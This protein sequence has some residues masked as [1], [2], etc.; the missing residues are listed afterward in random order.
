MRLLVVSDVHTEFHRDGGA[1]FISSLNPEGVDALVVA[2]DLCLIRDIVDVATRLC[3]RFP[4]VLYVTG[5][6]EYYHSTP[7]LVEEDVSAVA[8]AHSNFHWLNESVVTIHGQRFVGT[9]LWFPLNPIANLHRGHLNDFRVIRDFVPWV[10]DKNR[11]SQSFLQQEVRPGDVVVTHHLPSPRS[12][13]TRFIG[14]QLNAFFCCDM[15]SV[16]RKNQPK[17]WIHGHTHD[18][19]DYVLGEGGT[20]VV[21]NPFG[22]AGH[23][24]NPKFNW[25]LLIDV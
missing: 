9:T 13:P 7:R 23:E 25:R 2:G 22:Y 10:Y 12:I 21:C 19:A 18:S 3:D 1:S 20:R 4:H 8:R 14:S 15:E 16:I 6:H 24:E 5:N 11:R 17:V